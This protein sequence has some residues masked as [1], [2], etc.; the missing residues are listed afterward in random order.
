MLQVS[1]RYAAYFRNA[2]AQSIT[3]G[4]PRRY[5]VA[6]WGLRLESI[7]CHDLRGRHAWR[8]EDDS[9]FCSFLVVNRQLRR[10]RP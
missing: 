1:F 3:E 4:H 2:E 10:P 9:D 6:Q 5:T 8:A 7:E